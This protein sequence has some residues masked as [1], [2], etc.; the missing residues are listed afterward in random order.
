MGIDCM[1][2]KSSEIKTKIA[3][4]YMRKTKKELIDKL[5]ISEYQNH[6]LKAQ[7]ISEKAA[8]E[9][10]T[11]MR[12]IAQRNTKIASIGFVLVFLLLIGMK[13]VL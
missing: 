1:K 6:R 9:L 12:K 3:K 13:L 11:G 4:A 8:L 5:I 2:L 7:L 10:E